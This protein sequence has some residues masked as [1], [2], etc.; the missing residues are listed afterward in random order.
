MNWLVLI[1]AF[2]IAMLMGAF[3]AN[4]IERSRPG[5]SARRRL[6]AA[7]AVLPCFILLATAIGLALILVPGPGTGENM[8]DLALVVTA[9][10]GA[11]FAGIA[12]VGGL[13]GG[14][15]AQRRNPQ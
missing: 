6:W 15:F 10:I 3:L 8:Q 1:V 4:L 9:M 7:A 12:L 13:V 5:W 11:L 14:S 2:C